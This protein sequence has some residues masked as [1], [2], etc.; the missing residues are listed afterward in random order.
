MF[1]LTLG[2]R[3]RGAYLTFHRKANQFYSRLGVTADQF[4]VL[5]VLAEAGDLTQTELVRSVYS[6]PN[7]IAAM[8]ARLEQ[9]DLVRRRPHADDGRVRCV[10]LT[11]AGRALQ[12]RLYRESESLRADLDQLFRP[13]ERDALAVLL[14]RIPEGLTASR[15]AASEA[16]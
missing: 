3:L 11:A 13:E 2:M 14:G 5:T 1:G 10:S 8:L 9:R 16:D 6:D 7:T 4:V 12:R 15:S